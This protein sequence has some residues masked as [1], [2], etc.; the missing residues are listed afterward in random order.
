[1]LAAAMEREQDVN[2]W[3]CLAY[4]LVTV[5]GRMEPEQAAR[6][7][8]QAARRILSSGDRILSTAPF[9][10]NV[11]SS[12]TE[13]VSLVTSRLDA[14]QAASMLVA[15]LRA[16]ESAEIRHQLVPSLVSAA[17]R[18]DGAKDARICLKAADILIAALKGETKVD[19]QRVL[20][21]DIVSV[22]GR[23]DKTVAARPCGQAARS[24]ADA[25]RAM[26]MPTTAIPWRVLCR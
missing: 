7:C 15:A 3:G 4:G 16:A 26:P 24:L 25:F 13:L 20:A 10:F 17:G 5:A 2:N 19:I 6:M 14:S 1:M 12:G 22:V 9:S 21:E 23:S 11:Y 8:G 18:L